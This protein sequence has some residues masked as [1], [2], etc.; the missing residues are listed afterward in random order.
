[1]NFSFLYV[2]YFGHVMFADCGVWCFTFWRNIIRFGSQMVLLLI[3]VSTSIT[4]FRAGKKLWQ[5]RECLAS[6]RLRCLQKWVDV[7]VWQFAC[8]ITGMKNVF[9]SP[10]PTVCT[11]MP[12]HH[13]LSNTV[14]IYSCFMIITPVVQISVNPL[15]CNV[16]WYSWQVIWSIFGNTVSCPSV[17]LNCLWQLIFTHGRDVTFFVILPL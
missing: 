17:F 9:A 16:C 6:C 7:C 14:F 3:T 11:W 8:F 15:C 4:W 1:M 5:I 10:H 2:M 13:F 12:H